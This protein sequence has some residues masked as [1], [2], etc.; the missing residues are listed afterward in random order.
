MTTT[1]SFHAPVT[2]CSN[3]HMVITM[4]ASRRLSLSCNW[5]SATHDCGSLD[6]LREMWHECILNAWS[7]TL[8]NPDPRRPRHSRTHT[9]ILLHVVMSSCVQ[10]PPLSQNKF[11]PHS[12]SRLWGIGVSKVANSTQTDYSMST[13][14][15]RMGWQL[16]CFPQRNSGVALVCDQSSSDYI[17]CLQV[18]LFPSNESSHLKHSMTSQWLV[19]FWA[20]CFLVISCLLHYSCSQGCLLS[21]INP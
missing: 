7:S 19:V 15:I 10:K 20:S 4:V 6:G 8:V 17:H 3:A 21:R 2:C 18:A 5:L 12:T 9:C 1:Y 13:V 11:R 14:G 16:G